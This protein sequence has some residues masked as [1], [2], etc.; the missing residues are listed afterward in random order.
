MTPYKFFSFIPVLLLAGCAST[1]HI[2]EI[3]EGQYSAMRSGSLRTS[4][5][6]LLSALYEDAKAF[7]EKK[8][9]QVKV[10]GQS[11]DP[12]NLQIHRPAPYLGPTNT[13]EGAFA[14]GFNS[15]FFLTS[16]TM[17]SAS[18]R[19]IC[20]EKSVENDKIDEKRYVYIGTKASDSSEKYVD[21]ASIRTDSQKR[22]VSF[23]ELITYPRPQGV[24]IGI[25]PP[26][27][28]TVTEVEINCRKQTVNRRTSRPFADK[29]GSHPL[30]E[31]VSLPPRPV[32]IKG[33]KYLEVIAD[34][35]C[36]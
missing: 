20:V 8:G 5:A 15:T 27:Y 19:F 17:P 29:N 1:T 6:D 4:Q 32:S 18:V 33:I 2:N 16:G 22:I 9:L 35:Y 11:F 25:N 26:F 10:M 14:A 21:A 34:K 28:S 12:G 31:A 24:D 23:K 30:F 3:G 36:P 7:C 13:P